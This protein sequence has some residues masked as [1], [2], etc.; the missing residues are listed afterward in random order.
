MTK[1]EHDDDD[2]DIDAPIVDD[3]DVDGDYHEV[4][5]EFG[6]SAFESFRKGECDDDFRWIRLEKHV[7]D[8]VKNLLTPADVFQKIAEVRREQAQHGPAELHSRQWEGK[9]P[10]RTGGGDEQSTMSGEDV[11]GLTSNI[12]VLQFNALAE[13]LSCGPDAKIPFQIDSKDLRSQ[14]EKQIYGGFTE[15]QCPSVALDFQRRRWRVL[16]VLLGTKASGNSEIPEA[17]DLIALEEIDRYHGFF[18]PILKLFG[19]AAI[20]Q[21]KPTSPGVRMGWYSDGCCLF[22]KRN[23]FELVSNKR[24]EYTVGNQLAIVAVLRHK[25]SNKE[26]VVAVTHLKAKQSETNEMIRCRQL[27]QLLEEVDDAVSVITAK[28]EHTHAIPVLILGDFNAEPPCQHAT[29]SDSSIGRVLSYIRQPGSTARGPSSCFRSAYEIDPLNEAMYTTWKTRGPSTT[30][31]IIDY[32]F[33][34]DALECKA[35]LSIPRLE[36]TAKLPGLAYPSDHM[37]IAAKFIL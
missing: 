27:E 6:A 2:D 35:T 32:I 21:P 13:G 14:N 26:L 16:E 3:R 8:V 19:Y 34:S 11:N 25:P 1:E 17:F 22:W 33:Y 30:K 29:F 12:S 36:E 28:N 18:A 4:V 37:M 7:P 20:F 15:I 5:N 9:G 24:I 10:S 31:R 23:V